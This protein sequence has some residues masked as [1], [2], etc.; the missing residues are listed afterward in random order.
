[1]SD[2]SKGGFIPQE[3]LISILPAVLAGILILLASTLTAVTEY[4]P[5]SKF[6]EYF[7][8]AYGVV[9]SIYLAF[10]YLLFVSRSN[11]TLIFTWINSFFGGI[12]LGLLTLILPP[13][14]D[15][16]LGILMVV[17]SI[18]ASLVSGRAPAYFLVLSAMLIT[19]IIRYE[20]IVLLSQWVR[21]LSLAVVASIS[22]ETIQQ[23]KH[24]SRQQIN[25][26]EIVNK[27]S[28]QIA[29]TLNVQQVTSLLN[30]AI[31][32]ALEADTYYVGMVEGDEIYLHLFY[33]DGEYFTGV[34]AKME[35]TLSGWVIR[36][37]K[38]LF[39][40]DLRQDVNLEGVKIVIIGKQKTSLSWMGVPM[41]GEFTN[42]IIAIASYRPNAFGRSDMELLSNMAQRAALAL[43][44]AYH[45]A[46][47]EEQSHL[48]SLTGVYNHGYFLKVLNQQAETAFHSKQPLSLIML[49]IDHFK[50]YN[51][52]YGHLAGDVI[53]TKLCEAIRC[54]VK[55]N[56]AVGR[57]GGE[58]F[59]ISLPNSTGAQAM[60]VAYRI[61]ETLANMDL[62]SLNQEKIPVPT[63][64][65]GIAEFSREADEIFNLIDLADNRLY[66]AK[67]RGRDQ[68]EP[69][70]RHWDHPANPGGSTNTPSSH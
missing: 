37:K 10:F 17:A 70:A 16:L 48:D 2:K 64:S 49:D 8:I 19:L 23:L 15:T 24:L 35:G 52:T 30:A 43:D 21:Y 29:S 61:R 20:E 58:E 39:L 3:H 62:K 36:N 11:K 56:D 46:Q 12:S 55:R 60:Q 13:E 44:N 51:D 47:V 40:P 69:Q 50:Q 65:Q 26:L 63:I 6:Q 38:E 67:G 42:G 66:I 54:H 68:I 7:L 32:N 18:L 45:H 57:W 22:V 25:R 28:Q 53:L 41:Q 5:K 31:Q 33:D 14:M 4:P 27:F 59:A 9:G 34:R 1:M